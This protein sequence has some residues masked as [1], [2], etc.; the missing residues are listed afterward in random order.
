MSEITAL[1][2]EEKEFDDMG[3][4]NHSLVQGNLA[5]VI[6]KYSN[7]SAFIEL[8]LDT[9]KLDKTQFADVNNELIPDVCAYPRSSI[10]DLDILVMQEMP[11]LVIE[12][13]SP[14]QGAH[15]IVRKFQAYFALGICS[16]W[17]VDP[18]IAAV[19]VYHNNSH[20][21]TFASGELVDNITNIKFPVAE[22]FE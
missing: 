17:L 19:R 12:V 9:S 13:I 22:I 6:R 18:T 10:I 7:L 4:Y 3:S 1:L 11:E 8:S 21:Q 2:D 15:G 14:R 20:S 16:C 5:H